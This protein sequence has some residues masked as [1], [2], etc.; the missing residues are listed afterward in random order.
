ML[1]FQVTDFQ[2]LGSGSSN[3]DAIEIHLQ[4]CREEASMGKNGAKGCILGSLGENSF[5][6][7]NHC[8]C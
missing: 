5:W 1:S 2:L 8:Y 4:M 6:V 7:F 3:I